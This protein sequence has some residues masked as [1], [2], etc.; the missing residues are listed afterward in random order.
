MLIMK[1]LRP[2]SIS[3]VAC[4]CSLMWETLRIGVHKRNGTWVR[5]CV[6]GNRYML[7]LKCAGRHRR[8]YHPSL[9][10]A[11]ACS[12]LAY[13]NDVCQLHRSRCVQG[14]IDMIFRV[15]DEYFT[16]SELCDCAVRVV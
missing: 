12:N 9:Y 1:A 14:P 2:A 10:H 8:P 7:Q 11:T 3:D 16:S 4:G 6:R 13:I 15:N 5:I